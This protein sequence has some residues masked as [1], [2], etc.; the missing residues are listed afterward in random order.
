[1]QYGFVTLFAAAFPLAPLFALIN[2]IVE[3]RLDAYKFVVSYRRPMP[4]TGKDLGVWSDILNAISKLAVLTNVTYFDFM[5][6]IIYHT[7]MRNRVYIGF[8]TDIGVCNG[9]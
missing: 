8:Y 4:A 5:L 1:M 6:F 9:I 7:G 2:N 3:I